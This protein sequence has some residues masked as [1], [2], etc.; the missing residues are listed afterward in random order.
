MSAPAPISPTTI[1]AQRK[2]TDSQLRLF[3]RVVSLTIVLQS[4]PTSFVQS[5]PG[6]FI[7]TGNAIQITDLRVQ[8]SIKKNLGKEPNTC[9]V[10][11]SNLSP[12]TRA[13]LRQ[14]PL[15][16]ILAA[17]FDGVTNQLFSGN[18]TWGQSRRE[19]TEWETKLQISDGGRAFTYARMS[20]SYKP[21]I[22]P[23]QILTDAAATMGLTLPPEIEQDPVMRQAL[24]SGYTAHGPTRDVMTKVL[25]PYGYGWSIQDGRY[26][27]LNDKQVLQT[28]AFQ[29]DIDAGLIGTPELSVPHRP[30]DPSELT[31]EVLLYPQMQVGSQ[32]NLTSDSVNGLYRVNEVTHQGDN[33][34]DDWKTTMKATLF[35]QQPKHRK[36]GR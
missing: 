8:F 18:I 11:V 13:A 32:I 36:R 27:V 19:G 20:R 31:C 17:G 10:T 26:Q 33:F 34:G 30:S 29:I 35:G 2:V 6:Y 14:K 15:Y 4:P 1:L 28:Q 22:S 7:S 3:N 12:D 23:K 25:A 21:P 9:V 5:N 24:A 16:A